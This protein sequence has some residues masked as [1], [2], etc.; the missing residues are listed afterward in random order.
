MRDF[1]NDE[2]RVA[3]VVCIGGIVRQTECLHHVSFDKQVGNPR[4]FC[5]YETHDNANLCYSTTP[6]KTSMTMNYDIALFF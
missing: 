2:V 3:I 1:A 6:T 5:I 4:D